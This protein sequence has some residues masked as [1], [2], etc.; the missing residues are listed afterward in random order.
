[1]WDGDR[2]VE[3]NFMSP[4]L[5]FWN[6]NLGTSMN[7][8]APFGGL[9][10]SVLDRTF[11]STRVIDDTLVY[12]RM[13]LGESWQ[14]YLISYEKGKTSQGVRGIPFLMF[15]THAGKRFFS[16]FALPGFAHGRDVS[17]CSWWVLGPQGVVEPE[18][19]IPMDL[20]EPVFEPE[21]RPE[22]LPWPKL[23]PRYRGLEPFLEFP[24]RAKD[25]FLVVSMNTG[26]IWIVPEKAGTPLR[27]VKMMALSDDQLSGKQKHLPVI[28]DIQPMMNGNVL[29][30][31]RSEKV[32]REPLKG[33]GSPAGVEMNGYPGVGKTEPQGSQKVRT[34]EVVW[35]V[36]DPLEGKLEDPD[37]NLIGNAPMELEIDRPFSFTFDMDGILKVTIGARYSVHRETENIES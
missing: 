1:M 13:P 12:S 16:M 8:D 35:K 31:M 29:V 33:V 18:S 4:V 11:S 14:D 20:E 30:A 28:L 37:S 6:P 21:V 19:L 27:V 5:T 23:K 2:L 22:T 25:A 36:L 24:L 32:I 34:F 3:M 9:G 17:L 26:I 15:E 10:I 7:V